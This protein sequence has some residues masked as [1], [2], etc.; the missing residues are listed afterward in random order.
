MND[1]CDAILRWSQIQVAWVY[2]IDGRFEIRLM[3]SDY[4]GVR[5]LIRA[6]LDEP[7]LDEVDWVVIA[8][9][10]HERDVVLSDRGEPH[11]C[12]RPTA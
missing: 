10:E 4:K 6:L 9:P 5:S 8:H 12:V 1:I 3:G 7:A 11:A 2:L